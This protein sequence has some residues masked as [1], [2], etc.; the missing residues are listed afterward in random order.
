M[1]VRASRPIRAERARIDVSNAAQTGTWSVRHAPLVTRPRATHYIPRTGPNALLFALASSVIH[2]PPA[3]SYSR[4]V[5]FIGALLAT[6]EQ[7]V[8]LVPPL[9]VTKEQIDTALSVLEVTLFELSAV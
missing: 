8:R 9:V 2:V 6:W 5:A 4:S 3:E 7:V 1:V